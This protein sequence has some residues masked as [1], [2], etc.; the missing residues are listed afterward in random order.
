MPF[1]YKPGGRAEAELS[2][3]SKLPPRGD[4]VCAVAGARKLPLWGAAGTCRGNKCRVYRK[5]AT[6]AQLS[7][8]RKL[9]RGA[10]WGVAPLNFRLNSV[11]LSDWLE[12]AKKRC[13]QQMLPRAWKR[14]IGGCG[15]LVKK[16]SYSNHKILCLPCRKRLPIVVGILTDAPHGRP[17]KCIKLTV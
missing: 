12:A 4:V 10:K 5:K 2:F 3:Y 11:R 14:S 17:R 6:K 8:A 9:R 1:A 13:S 7:R 15:K 16:N